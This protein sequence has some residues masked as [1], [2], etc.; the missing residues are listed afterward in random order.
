MTLSDSAT[1]QLW[2]TF[3]ASGGTGLI[4]EAVELV[5]QALIEAEAAEAIGAGRYERSD[6]R[7]TERNGHRSRLLAT[8]AGDVELKIPTLRKGSFFPVDARA[9]PSHRPRPVGG[10]DGG[11]RGWGVDAVGGRP[12]GRFGRGVRYLAL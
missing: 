11:L 2:E 1:A 8:Q 4:R 9:A 12:R 6:T 3:R 5:L 7:V 10:G